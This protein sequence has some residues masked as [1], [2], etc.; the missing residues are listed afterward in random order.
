MMRSLRFL[1]CVLLIFPCVSQ[2]GAQSARTNP[3]L[4]DRMDSLSY[5]LGINLGKNLQTSG[6]SEVDPGI[7]SSALMQVLNGQNGTMTSAEA[8]RFIDQYVRNL[9]RARSEANRRAGLKFLEQNRTREGVV[10]RPSGLQYKVIRQGKG[11]RP[12]LSDQ[13]TVHYHGTLVDGTVFDSTLERGVPI[14]C[15]VNDVI[16]GWMEALLQMNVGS[17]WM[18][19]IPSD[20]AYGSS[21]KVG[22][23]E[24]NS[25]L[26]FEMELLDIN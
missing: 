7:L 16:L 26:I 10:V 6:I 5:S 20:L 14:Q 9:Q 13:V 3:V 18:L 2:A 11:P 22:L 15:Y 1:I 24:P 21:S 19:Y 17:K 25:T 4:K 8:T 23:V 12:N